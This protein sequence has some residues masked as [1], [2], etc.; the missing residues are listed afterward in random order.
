ME[1]INHHPLYRVHTID[2]AMNSLWDFYRKKFIP[3]FLTSFVMG[4]LLQYLSTL[5]NLN[6]IQ[7]ITTLDEMMVKLREYLWPM[8]I[9]SVISLLFTT[10][11]QY[12]IIYNP[13]DP[14]NNI[15]RSALKSLRYFVLYMIIMVF[16]VIAASFVLFLGLLLIVIGVLFAAIYVLM[17]YLFILPVMMIEGPSIAN[18]ITRTIKLA[19]RNFW[20][21]IGW[22]AVFV[23][24]ILVITTILSGLILVPFTGKFFQVF[25]NPSEASSLTEIF[26]NPLYIILSALVNA[27]TLPLLPIFASI[28]YFNGRAREE[29]KS[30]WNI[31]KEDSVGD[32]LKV[33]DLYSRPHSDENSDKPENS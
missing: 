23:V 7:S 3:L 8:I 21:N 19:H 22:T 28:L 18:T 6:E 15:L 16:L 4:L 1:Q 26:T 17:I 27:I 10:V 20:S 2:S 29:E 30:S 12:Y 9:V 11:L 33:E 31:Q 25:T 24:I 13:L 32:N 14:E 5:I